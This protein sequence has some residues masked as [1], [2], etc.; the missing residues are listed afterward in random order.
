M[1]DPVAL[2]FTVSANSVVCDLPPPVA[3]TLT[4]DIPAGV[5]AVVLMIRLVMHVGLQLVKVKEAPAPEGR[6]AAEKVT[7][8]DVPEAN[9]AVIEL[10]V[11]E[12]RIT[13]TSPPFESEKSNGAGVAI[14]VVVGDGVG[15]GLGVLVGDVV[16]VPVGAGVGVLVGVA[17]GV[18]VGVGV[19][20]P[21]S[22][23]K[24]FTIFGLAM[25][26]DCVSSISE[27]TD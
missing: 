8:C 18:G 7:A 21:V 4:V 3:V 1:A 15:V 17:V 9:W 11:D 23:Q 25:K 10:L 24:W 16:G 2:P 20:V 26:F 5:D 19:G 12:P 22:Q 6:P 14:G 27:K 13:E